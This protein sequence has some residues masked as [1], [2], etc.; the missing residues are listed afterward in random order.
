MALEGDE[1]FEAEAETETMLLASIAECDGGR[2]TPFADFSLRAAS[3]LTLKSFSLVFSSA[4][5]AGIGRLHVTTL[6]RIER[7]D[8]ARRFHAGAS[9]QPHEKQQFHDSDERI[10]RSEL[11]EPVR[12]E[13]D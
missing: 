13:P 11:H 5:S 12:Q 3:P 10:G 1:P 2:T 7:G 9:Y 4:L 6:T 8:F